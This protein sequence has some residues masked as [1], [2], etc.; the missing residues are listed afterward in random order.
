VLRGPKK[1][2]LAHLL[3]HSIHCPLILI[4]CTVLLTLNEQYH[5]QKENKMKKKNAAKNNRTMR[6]KEGKGTLHGYKKKNI[7]PCSP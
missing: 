3:L 4:A 1:G 2:S 5:S 6:K 7:M